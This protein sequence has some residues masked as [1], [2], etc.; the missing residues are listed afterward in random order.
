MK[1][2]TLILGSVFILL[3]IL[4]ANGCSTRNSL[5]DEDVTVTQ[6]WHQVENQYQRRMDLIPNLVAAVQNYANFEKSTL[7]EVVEARAK[8]SQVT[9][10]PSKL[11]AA[12]MQKFQEAQ[13]GVSSALGRL[14]V[15][16]EQYPQ[17]KANESFMG[18]QKQL[19]GTENRI[20]TARDDYNKVVGDYNKHIRRFPANI[21]A[22][23]FG[24]NAKVFFEMK[25]G[26]DVAPDVNKLFK[27]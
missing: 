1:S 4:F 11:D 18:L 14:H 19:E 17:L 25:E 12:S 27:K 3:L 8:A 15:V 22:G 16:V 13:G 21:W 20:G 10:D 2:N 6:A 7:V 24:F 23:M 26:A 9:V 5:V